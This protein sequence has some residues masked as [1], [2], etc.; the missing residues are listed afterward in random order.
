MSTPAIIAA[1][2][3]AMLLRLTS[4]LRPKDGGEGLGEGPVVGKNPDVTVLPPDEAIKKQANGLN[5]FLYETVF[6]GAWRNPPAPGTVNPPTTGPA[7]LGLDLRYLVTALSPD[8]TFPWD[9]R[10]LGLAMLELHER[11][12]F[13][14]AEILA[15]SARLGTDLAFDAGNQIERIRITPLPLSIEEMSKLW[16]SFQASYR[17]SVAYEVSV[18]LIDPK[19]P[20]GAALPVLSRGK[21]DG[22]GDVVGATLFPPFPTITDVAIESP[23][24][25]RLPSARV[26]DT[27]TLTGHH[28]EG[29]GLH[30]HLRRPG[31]TD[32]VLAE[33]APAP[34]AEP[35]QLRVAVPDRDDL[36]AG[37][38]GL[39][40][41]VVPPHEAEVRESNR[42][43][44]AIAPTI[45]EPTITATARPE[46]LAPAALVDIEVTV[47]PK[48]RLGQ[49]ATLLVG[50]TEVLASALDKI[51]ADTGRAKLTFSKVRLTP[52]RYYL[53]LRVDDVESTLILGRTRPRKRTDPAM[54]FDER[55]TITVT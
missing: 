6:S 30:V 16:S 34:G 36:R 29:T 50:T 27:I 54:A 14:V 39:S 18:V 38:Y 43:P 42:V 19:K 13:D 48:V 47:N 22:E 51:D 55:Q 46:N 37:S 1:V 5:V 26:G 23:E 3:N 44:V 52:G 17:I 11:P 8:Q 49:R 45:T 9:H 35:N 40:V 4:V 33:T 31:T 41:S 53:R 10:F 2:T 32:D 21:L 15:A 20:T 28:F 25:G 24:F 12:L 7:P